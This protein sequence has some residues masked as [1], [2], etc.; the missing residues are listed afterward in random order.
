MNWIYTSDKYGHTPTVITDVDE[1]VEG[2]RD[3]GLEPGELQHHTDG[4]HEWYT[5]GDG[6]VILERADTVSEERK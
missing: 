6:D 1:F 3:A 5:D 4:E 2:L